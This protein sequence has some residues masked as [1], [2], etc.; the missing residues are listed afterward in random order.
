MILLGDEA[1]WNLV[2]VQLETELASVPE[3]CTVGME[4]TI[5]LE[6]ILEALDGT[7]M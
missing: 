2:L 7:P 1:E 4:R 3:R 5:G 6:I